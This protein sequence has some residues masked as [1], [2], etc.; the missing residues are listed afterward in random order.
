MNKMY[1]RDLARPEKLCNSNLFKKIKY[2]RAGQVPPVH[3]LRDQELIFITI[4]YSSIIV[5]LFRYFFA[6]FI[7]LFNFY[8]FGVYICLIMIKL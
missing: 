8:P 3:F 4:I 5:I 6:F 7:I 2:N 1:G